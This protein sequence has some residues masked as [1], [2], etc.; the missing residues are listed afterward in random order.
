MTDQEYRTSNQ[1][2]H[3][4]T[5]NSLTNNQLATITLKIKSWEDALLDFGG[6]NPLLNYRVSRS[7]TITI[8]EPNVEQ[9][10][11][12][13]LDGR[14]LSLLPLIDD[15][16]VEEISQDIQASLFIS[17]DQQRRT[18]EE[19]SRIAHPKQGQL[20]T[21]LAADK[22]RSA[23]R[24][25]ERR[26]RTLQEET[27][28]S[29]LYAAFGWLN[30]Q[31]PNK[32][33][34]ISPLVLVPVQFT[35]KGISDLFKLEFK[36][37]DIVL[38]PTLLSYM[39][40]KEG[41]RLPSIPEDLGAKELV[42]YLRQLDGI[43]RRRNWQVDTSPVRLA[44][45]SFQQQVIVDDLQ[46]HAEQLQNDVLI[47][48][49]ALGSEHPWE[50][51]SHFALKEKDLD[52]RIHIADVH[53]I[54]DADSSQQLAIEAAKAGQSFVLQ[55]PPGT[56]K[57][58]TIAN[59]IAECLAMGRHVLFVSA[60]AAALEVVLNRLTD[61]GLD[62]LCLQV[63]SHKRDKRQVIKDL[64][65]AQ[66]SREATI[67]DLT[68]AQQQLEAQQCQ[69]NGYVEA[70]TIKRFALGWSARD[71]LAKR[72]RLAGT[73]DIYF[74]ILNAEELTIDKYETAKSQ[75]E[76]LTTTYGY[77]LDTA[78][79]HP[80][81]GLIPN[82]I[83]TSEQA[84]FIDLGKR[85]NEALRQ[86]ISL[87]QDI[88]EAY[89]IQS[90][91]TL[92]QANQLAELA[93]TFKPGILQFADLD[94][95]ED[96]YRFPLRRWTSNYRKARDLFSS[97]LQEK[98]KI[99][100]R[101]SVKLISK[102][103][104]VRSWAI[105]NDE[106]HPLDPSIIDNFVQNLSLV[107][108]LLAQWNT[109]FQTFAQ[110]DIKAAIDDL[111]KSL[112]RRLAQENSLAEWCAF[113]E[114]DTQARTTV[115]GPMLALAGKHPCS[116]FIDMFDLRLA[117]ILWDKAQ[118]QDERLKD[119]T[120]QMHQQVVDSF[121][122]LDKKLIEQAPKCLLA[123]DT[124]HK[125]D[126]AFVSKNTELSILRHEANKKR[127]VM[128]LRQLFQAIPNLI[129]RT[130]P[131]LMMSPMTVSQL[132]DPEKYHFDLVI[133]D[134]ASQ[135]RAEEA[136]GAIMR[137]QQVIVAGDKQ[138]LPPTSFFQVADDDSN[139]DIDS[140]ESILHEADAADLQ[141]RMLKWHYRSRN[142]E[143]IA[144]SNHN[145]YEDK[146]YTFPSQLRG[147]GSRAVSFEYVE[148]AV[149]GRGTSQRNEKEAGRVVELVLDHYRE[150][151][152]K[153]VGVVTFNMAQ[154]NYILDLLEEQ[155]KD[156]PQIASYFQTDAAGEQPFAKNLET[157][158]GDERD[159]MIFSIGYG[160]A[161]D[162]RLSLNFGPL[163]KDG[164]DKRLNV[165]ITRAR[166]QVIIVSSIQPE[167]I[168]AQ[169]RNSASD[170]PRLLA[171]YMAFA[172]DGIAALGNATA[173]R[174]NNS[175]QFDSSLEECIYQALVDRRLQVDT[176]IG[177]SS[178]RIDLGVIH[179]DD[180][181]H[182]IL[183]I[184]CD[185]APYHSS[186]SARDRDRLRQE[187]L[188]N[189]GWHIL[190][191]WSP[192]WV[193]NPEKEIQ[194]VLER[195][196]ELRNGNVHGATSRITRAVEIPTI[197]TVKIERPEPVQPYIP[198]I[199]QRS[200]LNRSIY[201]VNAVQEAILDIVNLEG[202]IHV[203]LLIKRIA[204][205]FWRMGRTGQRIEL[206]VMTALQRLVRKR[207]IELAEDFVRIPGKETMLRQKGDRQFE[208]ISDDEIVLAVLLCVQQSFSILD[209]D[210]P[211]AVAQVFGFGRA[212][213]KIQGR[214]SELANSLIAKGVLA[215]SK[216][217]ISL[218]Q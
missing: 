5:N 187:V 47:Q 83:S 178:Y 58:Q 92:E 203:S 50:D 37:E 4:T 189:K 155:L 57:S 59:I 125:S 15:E 98:D 14:Q 26:D 197:W 177:V 132:L 137:A 116:D 20:A 149:Y 139:E 107:H 44:T 188:E 32:D 179:P 53:Q 184:E 51:K 21:D 95:F 56:G 60:K 157:V 71:L 16:N 136:V 127:R 213:Q 64:V 118:K 28:I 143:L 186:P 210:I 201:D 199:P 85:A 138:Q 173:I 112:E 1:L 147:K 46:N 111:S 29:V 196:E 211:S 66:E 104:P 19:P 126:P 123:N 119:S 93:G 156:E 101:Q 162:G 121:R 96:L 133:F 100:Y 198:A 175:P 194:R 31:T 164:G 165:A 148:G 39:E 214:I 103:L 61:V 3:E 129:L 109:Y 17:E 106:F 140:F 163:N 69:L 208:Q 48:T 65:D 105:G 144:F 88:S 146:L 217:R 176:Q 67:P 6:R 200:Y 108:E 192:D 159:V 180:D 89:S 130:K 35:R 87:G 73:P 84:R 27:G 181:S 122:A 25:L 97:Y 134:E 166:D 205:D 172:R 207:T 86:A 90:P 78:K 131:C 45:L 22:L 113:S 191:I 63:H 41:L 11:K 76:I 151:P 43:F 128:S 142:E 52:H 12:Q 120:L 167:D 204:K 72:A 110:L 8:V 195:V 102:T 141:N 169:L 54:L 2:H 38:N 30:W 174:G 212:T 7:S 171:D 42:A 75:L 80:W 215:K 79:S 62:R 168:R 115:L 182:Y 160:K 154:R 183:G 70:L 145:W 135:L 33:S 18:K 124:L 158:Q 202:P 114:L 94:T 185:G 23:I 82:S 49:M 99:G 91:T 117:L 10:A 68:Q 206:T 74:D 218:V 24:T 190:R 153:S 36:E 9:V 152:D 81:Y 170:G 40:Q 216:D 77:I 34:R 161:E 150:H 193:R 209:T 55:G 13:L